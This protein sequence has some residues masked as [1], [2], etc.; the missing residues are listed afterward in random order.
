VTPSR[1]RALLIY[2]ANCGFCKRCAAAAEA[3]AGAEG[4][5]VIGS[6]EVGE[7]VP[8]LGA[9]DYARAVQLVRPDGGVVEGAEA[10][11]A[12]LQKDLRSLALAWAHMPGFKGL[13]CAI[14][15]WVAANRRATNRMVS[16]LFGADLRPTSNLRVRSALFAA[17]LLVVC[18]LPLAAVFG[19]GALIASPGRN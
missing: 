6:D 9:A 10:V 18:A 5:E 2:D 17:P 19:L 14:Y 1:P 7:R 4:I 11:V 3:V 12:V 13:L 16:A 8:T 15:R